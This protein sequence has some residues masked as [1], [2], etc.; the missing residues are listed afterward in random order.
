MS[1][2]PLDDI[3]RR[4]LFEL[5]GDGRAPV[6][7]L[8]KALHVS[9]GTVQVRLDRLVRDGVIRRFTIEIGAGADDDVVRAVTTIQVSGPQAGPVARHLRGM[10]SVRALHTTNG[11]WDLVAELSAPNLG[12][13]DATLTEIRS[14]SG[15]ANTETSI[16]LRPL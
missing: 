14:L 10:T 16:L 5:R 1:M 8:A 6:T 11:T 15:V 13:L 3:D 4:L 7:A 9:R 2:R 12:M